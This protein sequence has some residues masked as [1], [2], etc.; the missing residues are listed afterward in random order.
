M[1]ALRRPV[2]LRRV[3]QLSAL[4]TAACALAVAPISPLQA[5]SDFQPDWFGYDRPATYEAIKTPTTVEVR[6]GTPIACDLWRPGSDGAVAAGRFPVVVWEFSAYALTHD[7][8]SPVPVAEPTRGT[9]LAPVGFVADFVTEPARY[10]ASRGYVVAV[11]DVRGTGNSGGDFPSWF[12]P[13]EAQDNYDLIEWLARQP[14]STGKVGQGGASYASLTT[15]RVA[16]LNPPHLKAIVPQIAIGNLYDWAYPGGIPSK[17][18]PTWAVAGGAL[19]YGTVNPPR[20]AQSF[21][22]H[23][24]YDDYWRQIDVTDNLNQIKVPTLL[25]G[26]WQDILTDGTVKS[27]TGRSKNTW[28]V[29]NSGQHVPPWYDANSPVP[30]GS[31]LAW[32][33][34]WLMGVPN[35]PLPSERVTSFEGPVAG[36]SGW[37]EFGAWPPADVGARRLYLSADRS[38]SAGAGPRGNSAYAVNPFDGPSRSWFGNYSSYTEDPWQ[39]QGVADQMRMTYTTSPL[40][41]DTVLAGSATAHL[42]AALSAPDGY[43]VVKVEDVAPDGRV[44]AVTEGYLKASHREGH[45]HEVILT[46]SQFYDYE[47][48]IRPTHWRFAEGHRMR[49]AI[50]SGD[51]PLIYPDAPAGTVTVANGPGG[52]WVEFPVR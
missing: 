2:K 35:A 14:W 1:S 26:G 17:E 11:C 22:A 6:D 9:P 50:T 46:P 13:K 4:G 30:I 41:E 24:L 29:M 47:I 36:R 38:L 49:I 12:Q 40:S 33:D 7:A 20:V 27:F 3:L 23:P 32:W 42:R 19:A 44:I 45:E 18:G 39:D 48:A 21:A 31:V 10:F 8:S 28:L 16:A 43:F 51:L 37:K 15:Q 25:I 5:S 52:S 34:H